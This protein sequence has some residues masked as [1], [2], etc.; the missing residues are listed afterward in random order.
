MLVMVKTETG[1]PHTTNLN[2]SK[3]LGQFNL[4]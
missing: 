4:V 3:I 1:L 2:Y